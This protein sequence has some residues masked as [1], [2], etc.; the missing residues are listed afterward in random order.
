MIE[1]FI[2]YNDDEWHVYSRVMTNF[3]GY[4]TNWVYSCDTREEA[5]DVIEL[6][7]REI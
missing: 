2:D 3:G 7:E 4:A 6:L 1:Y 5:E